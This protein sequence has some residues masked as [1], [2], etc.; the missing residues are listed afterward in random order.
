MTGFGR[1]GFGKDVLSEF[2]G[3]ETFKDVFMELIRVNLFE[4][5]VDYWF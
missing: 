2:V 3:F 4:D 5:L 1:N